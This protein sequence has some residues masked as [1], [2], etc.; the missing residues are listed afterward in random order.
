MALRLLQR[1]GNH[2]RAM[3]EAAALIDVET[4]RMWNWRQ[5]LAASHFVAHKLLADLSRDDVVIL[6]A[7]NEPAFVAA[8]LGIMGAGLESFCVSAAATA[9]ELEALALASGAVAAIGVNVK[10]RLSIPLELVREAREQS[11]VVDSPEHRATDRSALLLQSSGTTGTPKIVR[12]AGSSLD[13]ISEAMCETIGFGPAD[14]VLAAAPL[15]HSYGLEHGLLAPVWAGSCVHLCR[16]FDVATVLGELAGS[17]TIFPGVPFMFETLAQSQGVGGKLR[18]AYS[19]GGPLPSA[20][21]QQFASRFGVQVG[22]VYGTTEVG[23]V[24]FNDPNLRG[25]SPAS[26]GRPMKGVCIEI[27]S[28]TGEVAVGAPWMFEGYVGEKSGAHGERFPTGDLG[29]LD[30]NGNLFITGRLKLIIDVGGRKVNPL[31]VESVLA[32]H[33]EVA[34]CVVVPMP[35]V[36]SVTRLKAVVIPRRPAE[37]PS[38]GALRRFVK[39]RLASYKVPRVFEVREEL[40]RSSS[41]K[42][43]RHLIEG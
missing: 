33:P 2:A 22:Q 8:F 32:D 25:F 4:G 42:I 17:I 3:P 31:E 43:L 20:A 24:T 6:C 7:E 39:D 40:P 18:R 26:V 19:A 5:F 15:G 35:L 28:E 9:A 30:D 38:P 13:A 27:D 1:L 29:G 14:H 21:G 41:G 10:N 37:P 16:R 23:S 36:D 12:R 34:Q 11:L